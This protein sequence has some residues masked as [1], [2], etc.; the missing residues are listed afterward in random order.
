MSQWS[1]V[2]RIVIWR[3]LSFFVVD[4][5]GN[6]AS[7]ELWEYQ[8][9]PYP[10]KSSATLVG[11]TN[12]WSVNSRTRFSSSSS[13]LSTRSPTSCT[14]CIDVRISRQS[15]PALVL[16]I[17]RTRDPGSTLLSAD[18]TWLA[19]LAE[20][21]KRVGRVSLMLEWGGVL[22]LEIDIEEEL[23]RVISWSFKSLAR[24]AKAYL[25]TIC[26]RG[27]N[28]L[29]KSELPIK[30]PISIETKTWKLGVIFKLWKLFC[31]QPLHNYHSSIISKIWLLPQFWF[32]WYLRWSWVGFRLNCDVTSMSGQVRPIRWRSYL[33]KMQSLP[34]PFTRRPTSTNCHKLPRQ[35]KAEQVGQLIQTCH[36]IFSDQKVPWEIF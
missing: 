23:C 10:S 14:G 30:R 36:A 5:V 29:Q 25:N 9:L 22:R 7:W 21:R 18:W 3:C 15:F 34:T 31:L 6:V 12:L 4:R 11:S 1:Q 13:V 35:D 24:P 17:C 28:Q 27:L 20:R 2:S 33:H 26:Q 19:K 16:S 32:H 8:S